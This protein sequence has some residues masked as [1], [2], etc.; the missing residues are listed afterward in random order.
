MLSLYKRRTRSACMLTTVAILY[1]AGLIIFL[2]LFAPSDASGDDKKVTE[3]Y[4][5]SERI[6]LVEK[7]VTP[8]SA[9]TAKTG[10]AGDKRVNL[11]VIRKNEYTEIRG[12]VD[13]KYIHMRKPS[14]E[15]P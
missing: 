14:N 8:N 10:W 13:G 15:N 3:G 7:P 1:T 9:V 2:T 12:W 11:R 6:K 4:Y 5:G